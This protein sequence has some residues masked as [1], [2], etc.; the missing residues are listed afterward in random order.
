MTGI[1]TL[2]NT[3]LK[4]HNGQETVAAM[5]AR[6]KKEAVVCESLPPQGPKKDDNEK[7]Y[8]GPKYS[9]MDELAEKEP[10]ARQLLD[11]IEKIK[12]AQ[13]KGRQGYRV[14][15]DM[16]DLGIKSGD[17]LYLDSFHGDHI[18]VFN[19]GPKGSAP[20]QVISVDGRILVEKLNKAKADKRKCPF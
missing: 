17:K 7:R 8:D 3:Q 4:A 5:L 20:R 2:L 13:Y 9:N 10:F 16:P 14:K 6:L 18:E 11:N 15:N 1:T 19:A 12:G